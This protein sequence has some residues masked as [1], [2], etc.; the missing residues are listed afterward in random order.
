MNVA[1]KMTY[2]LEIMYINCYILHYNQNFIKW[3]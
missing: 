3:R 2:L 1:A